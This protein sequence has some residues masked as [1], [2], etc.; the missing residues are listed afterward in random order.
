[1]GDS[2]FVASESGDNSSPVVNMAR[3]Q[4]T[5]C[6]VQQV[7]APPLIENDFVGYRKKP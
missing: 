5:S 4:C 7:D 1:M 3:Y 2:H 6:H